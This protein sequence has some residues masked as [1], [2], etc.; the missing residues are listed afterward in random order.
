MLLNKQDYRNPL[1]STSEAIKIRET[2]EKQKDFDQLVI[3]GMGKESLGNLMKWINE[4]L[5]M[6]LSHSE[7]LSGVTAED[8]PDEISDI[9][10]QLKSKEARENPIPMPVVEVQ[11]DTQTDEEEI[12]AIMPRQLELS[13]PEKP[14]TRKR[15]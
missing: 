13:M 15:K 1:L 11:K 7:L 14:R 9:L 4:D 6:K 8:I 12:E 10:N 3:V 5:S 2:Y